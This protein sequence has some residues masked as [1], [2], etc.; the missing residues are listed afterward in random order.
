MRVE[1]RVWFLSEGT[2]LV[3]RNVRSG[4]G[5]LE[6]KRDEKERRKRGGGYLH[7]R[8]QGTTDGACKGMA[9]EVMVEAFGALSLFGLLE[10]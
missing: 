6:G 7:W 4:L 1:E 10:L 8:T 3:T 5:W 9:V 2:R